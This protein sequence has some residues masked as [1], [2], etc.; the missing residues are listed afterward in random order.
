MVHVV[1]SL[2]RPPQA[3]VDAIAGFGPATLHEA[4]GRRGALDWRIKPISPGMR[5]C[6]PAVTA[7]CTPGDN[8]M[9]QAAISI[10]ERGD[11]LVVDAGDNC[12][13]G[14]FGEV[15]ATACL[16]RGIAGL[17]IN[18][19]VRDAPAI[20]GLGFATFSRGLSVKGTV[21]ETLGEV[22]RPIVVGGIAIRPGDLVCGD[23]DGVVAVPAEEAPELATR[24]QER[25]D[26]E[27]RQKER[28][29]AGEGVLEVLGMAEVL[30]AK[31]C[32]WSD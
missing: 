11:V 13:Q 5:L 12:E 2:Q 8:L 22:N 17:V 7:R 23:D 4:Q 1:R 32:T 6:G 14:G 21:K 16:A 28:L 24:A 29:R 20:R 27:A 9:L 15:L 10:A 19:A 3:L 25:E 31:G 18:A 30:A 26:K